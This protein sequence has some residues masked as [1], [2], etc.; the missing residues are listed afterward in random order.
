MVQQTQLI[1]MQNSFG[2]DVN[3]MVIILSYM[4]MMLILD[5]N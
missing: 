2:V 3:T 5:T 4:D 1:F